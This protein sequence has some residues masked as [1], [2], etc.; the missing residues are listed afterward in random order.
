[1]SGGTSRT[2]TVT[3]GQATQAPFTVDC[4]TPPPPTG[5]LI[6]GATTT[7]GTPDPNGYT[8]TVDGA[9]L[10]TI[11]NNGSTPYTGLTPGSHVVVLGDIA[12][13]CTV[14]GGASHTVT[15]VAGQT[16]T[17]TFAVD[18]PTP[19]P[20]NQAPSVNAGPDQN[21]LLSALFT[22]GASFSD[23]DNGPWSFTIDWGDGTSSSGNASSPGAINGTHTYLLPGSYR[24]GVTVRD[25]RGATGSDEMILTVTL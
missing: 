5:D 23:P 11:G 10:R 25:S 19:P 15:V 8:V 17:E 14:S 3:A 24:I 20:P 16:T 2:V 9:Q 22:L 7:G 1:M 12:S 4:P 13:N 21:A 18:C 6:V